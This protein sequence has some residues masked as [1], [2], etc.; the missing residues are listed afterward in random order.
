MSSLFQSTLALLKQYHTTSQ[1]LPPVYTGKL[2]NEF[3][4]VMALHELLF[5]SVGARQA[6]LAQKTHTCIKQFVH[7]VNHFYF[8]MYGSKAPRFAEQDFVL[9][10]C[11][12]MANIPLDASGTQMA[13]DQASVD[14]ISRATSNIIGQVL[15]QCQFT[16]SQ[17]VKDNQRAEAQCKQTR[18]VGTALFILMNEFEHTLDKEHEQSHAYVDKSTITYADMTDRERKVSQR[19]RRN[20]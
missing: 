11:H 18:R 7:H 20:R 3:D 8:V 19:K 4:V 1:A 14:R 9:A 16:M 2:Q 12:A 17:Y 13:L 5:V 10:R 15:D 6:A